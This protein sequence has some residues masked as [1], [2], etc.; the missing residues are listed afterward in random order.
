MDIGLSHVI[1]VNGE[2]VHAYWDTFNPNLAMG[3]LHEIAIFEEDLALTDVFAKLDDC[4]VREEYEGEFNLSEKTETVERYIARYQIELNTDET[5]I[6]IRNFVFISDGK[7]WAI[8]RLDKAIPVKPNIDTI[9]AFESNL[10]VNNKDNLSTTPWE[11]NVSKFNIRHAAR[12]STADVGDKFVLVSTDKNIYD[13]PTD[14]AIAKS[15][16]T[17]G[18][19]IFPNFVLADGKIGIKLTA[20]S[21]SDI[22]GVKAI[23]IRILWNIGIL[24]Y[25]DSVEWNGNKLNNL[26][27][28][29]GHQLQLLFGITFR[30]VNNEPS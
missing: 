29:R 4:L 24:V 1:T 20:K 23:F 3:K 8:C 28:V 11:I 26:T 19:E 5:G 7:P 18:K 17:T 2:L 27:L 16:E 14:I 21:K 25:I 10:L 15:I 6:N 22:V 12:I 30:E 9:F 13:Q